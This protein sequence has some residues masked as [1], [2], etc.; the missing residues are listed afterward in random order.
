MTFSIST[1][2][3]LRLMKSG[4]SKMVRKRRSV[5]RCC[6]SISST[7]SRRML[8]SREVRQTSRKLAKAATKVLLW[9]CSSWMRCIKPCARSGMLS[10]KV[11]DSVLK[12]GDIGGSIVEEGVKDGGEVFGVGQ[13]GF[14]HN[15]V[16]LVENSAAGVLEDGV[17]DGVARTDLL[18]DLSGQVV[19]CVLGFPVASWEVEAITQGAI[20]AFTIGKCLFRNEHPVG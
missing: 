12:G 17:G 11:L 15:A 5:S 16:I 20:G 4:L 1:A 19:S 18:A 10:L 7:V 13:F 3:T 14:E 6:T 8:G 9:A 2:M